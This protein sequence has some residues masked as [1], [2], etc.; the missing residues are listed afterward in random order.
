MRVMTPEQRRERDRAKYAANPEYYR[1]KALRYARANKEARAEYTRK[2]RADNSEKVT[3]SKARAYRE[4]PEK[5]AAYAKKYRQRH[6][7]RNKETWRRQNLKKYGLTPHQVAVMIGQQE[8]CCASCTN[9]IMRGTREA[10]RQAH[11][12]HCH[13]TGRVRGILC[14]R[15][16]LILGHAKDQPSVLIA[17]AKY[18]T[19]RATRERKNDND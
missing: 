13:A 10:K 14:Q 6:P 7:E 15:C 3:A 16:N 2:Y 1:N 19:D 12:D 18:L 9:V 4:H 11:V 8:G 5:A 17:A